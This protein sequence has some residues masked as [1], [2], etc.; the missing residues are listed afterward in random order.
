M[1]LVLPDNSSILL[2]NK[3][4]SNPRQLILIDSFT[5]SKCIVSNPR[6]EGLFFIPLSRCEVLICS[7]GYCLNGGSCVALSNGEPLCNCVNMY[8]GKRCE[9]D[10]C[11]TRICHNG[12]QCL[13]RPGI[14]V[15]IAVVQWLEHMICT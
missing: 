13:Q 2:C 6:T 5:R 10:P 12:G 11:V 3:N 9:K 1:V 4:T 7:A 8:S 15:R 14:R